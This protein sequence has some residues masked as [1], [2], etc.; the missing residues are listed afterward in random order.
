MRYVPAVSA[1]PTGLNDDGVG[2]VAAAYWIGETEVTYELW[3]AVYQWAISS[4]RG[5]DIYSFSSG[6]GVNGSDGSGTSQPVTT[7]SWRD[8]IVWCNALTEYYNALNNTSYQCVYYLDA[9]YTTPIRSSNDDTSIVYDLGTQDNPYVNENAKG[10]RLPAAQEWELAARYRGNDS[11]NT[12]NGFS[13]PYFT[14]GDSASGATANYTNETVTAEVAWYYVNI[15]N[16]TGTHEVADGITANTLGLYDVSG[17]VWEWCY[18]YVGSPTLRMI[19]GGSWSENIDY[20]R[21]GF[22]DK[23]NPNSEGSD[24]GFRLVKTH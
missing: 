1:F 4:E 24:I 16:S 11:L 18:D 15:T 6:H 2:S 7:I 12:V 8:V 14:K 20:M 9:D 22:T 13:N 19:R 5:L 3:D 21:V 17:N 23:T 10:F